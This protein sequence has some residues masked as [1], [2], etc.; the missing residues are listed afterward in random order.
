MMIRLLLSQVPARHD[1]SK[2]AGCRAA[3]PAGPAPRLERSLDGQLLFQVLHSKAQVPAGP[4]GEAWEGTAHE[5]DKTDFYQHARHDLTGPLQGIRVIDLTRAWAGPMAGCILADL[6]CDVIRIELPGGREGE[7]APEIPGTGLSWFRQ[8]VHRN[9]RSL[10]LDVRQPAGHQLLMR[11]LRV[12]DVLLENFKPG[13]LAGWGLAYPDS[14]AVKPDIVYVSISGW[15]QY[16][17]G[18]HRPGYDP[19]AQ[20]ASGWMSLNGDPGG[21]PVKAPTFLAD[22]VAGLHGALAALA[23][24]RHRDMTGEGQHVDV[25]LFD[26]LLFQSSGF[27][28][29]AASGVPMRRWGDQTQFLVPCNT[30]RCADG[31]LYIAVA[32]DRHWRALTGVLGHPELARASGFA[33]NRERCAN[34]D[35]VNSVVADW[36]AA[37]TVAEALAALDGSGITAAAVRSFGEAAED[38]LV[39]E[40]DL[41][42][43]TVLSN[44]SQAPITGPPAKFSRTPTRVR[45]GAPRVGCHTDEILEDL[46]IG[47]E[48]RAALR[49]ARVI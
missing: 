34:R 12:T 30:F 8:T 28:T 44:G 13:T 43:D 23:A 25:S 24:L 11:L 16:G 22:D 33:T 4:G 49:S 20:A 2:S 35:P 29:L 21:P 39:R 36:C 3:D 18:S 45:S 37:R 47:A 27:L 6:G 10:S 42:Q 46:G 19:V 15:G 38:P 31:Y 26:C 40:R 41:L 48:E 1:I 9:K 14:R 5:M 17:S 7:F 32:L